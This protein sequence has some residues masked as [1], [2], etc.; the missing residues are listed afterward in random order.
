MYYQNKTKTEPH[1]QLSDIREKIDEQNKKF[2]REIEMIKR[3]QTEILKS[4]I[5]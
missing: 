2:N 5:T 3:N 1:R 4:K